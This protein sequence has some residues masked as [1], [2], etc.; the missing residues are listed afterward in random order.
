MPKAPPETD[1]VAPAVHDLAARPADSE[2][3]EGRAAGG[4]G[5]AG[6]AAEDAGRSVREVVAEGAGED[7]PVRPV[8]LRPRRR[9]HVTAMGARVLW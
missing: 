8:F 1:A 2:V 3:D 4:A 5:E 9:G 7:G 6:A